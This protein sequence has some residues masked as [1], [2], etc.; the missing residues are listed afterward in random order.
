VK[1]KVIENKVEDLKEYMGDVAALVKQYVPPDPEKIQAAAQNGKVALDK[2]TTP[3]VAKLA[4]TDYDLPADR[5]AISFN[6]ATKQLAAVNVDSYLGKEKDTVTL[7]VRFASLP[8]GVNY[9]AET[10]LVAKAKQIQVKITNN[11]YK[12]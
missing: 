6:S 12:K 3:G 5:L 7:A 8:D 4:I 11:G 10:V 2:E 1:K 9:P